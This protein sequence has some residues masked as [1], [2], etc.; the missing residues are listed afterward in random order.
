MLMN[1]K[2]ALIILGI[3][4][5][6][7]GVGAGVVCHGQNEEVFLVKD[8][9]VVLEETAETE[10]VEEVESAVTEMN[11]EMQQTEEIIEE[12]TEAEQV[13]TEESGNEEMTS[14]IIEAEEKKYMATAIN[15]GKSRLMIR[16]AGSMQ[17]NVISYMRNGDVVEVVELGEE[18]HLIRF[19]KVEGYV[20]AKYLEVTE[21]HEE[22]ETEEIGVNASE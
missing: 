22:S 12:T 9:I 20:S 2:K 17:G 1:R 4:Y 19:R 3:L 21:V 5:G 18:W 7:S 11:Q 16:D 10:M 15:V 8:E 13:K 6:V 14:E